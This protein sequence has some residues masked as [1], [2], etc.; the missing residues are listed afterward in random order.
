V[1]LRY[2][3]GLIKWD[4][5]KDGV[6]PAIIG[7]FSLGWNIASMQ[8][9]V[10]IWRLQIPLGHCTPLQALDSAVYFAPQLTMVVVF[11]D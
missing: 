11:D 7:L 6:I 3:I 10:P 1:D 8:S 2:L 4:W 5:H 9:K